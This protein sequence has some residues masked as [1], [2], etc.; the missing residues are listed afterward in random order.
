MVVK[1]QPWMIVAFSCIIISAFITLFWGRDF[2][3]PRVIYIFPNNREEKWP[4]W[5][6]GILLSV[7]LIIWVALTIAN[8][9]TIGND[10]LS[11]VTVMG[12]SAVLLYVAQI[13]YLFLMVLFV[14]M[15]MGIW[16]F[17]SRYII[18]D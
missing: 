3:S 11:L 9:T 8:H 12:L 14:S 6:C 2:N 5:V 1:S 13:V 4:H 10:I 18:R 7:A 17:V 16:L 15:I